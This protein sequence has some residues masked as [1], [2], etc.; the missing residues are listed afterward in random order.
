M[1]PGL[2]GLGQTGD[3]ATISGE[4]LVRRGCEQRG[5]RE[6]PALPQK[7]AGQWQCAR[8]QDR[9]GGH[10][11]TGVRHHAPGV[12]AITGTSADSVYR[13]R[14]HA[15]GLQATQLLYRS[16]RSRT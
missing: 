14:H 8:G 1:K 3:L 11:A 2:A 10:R 9:P 6:L 16:I 12:M 5:I 4:K 15:D 13:Y 7:E